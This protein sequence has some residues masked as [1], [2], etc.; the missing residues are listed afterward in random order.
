MAILLQVKVVSDDSQH[1]LEVLVDV[2]LRLLVLRLAGETEEV[3]DDTLGIES[4]FLDRVEQV[5][6]LGIGFG[7]LQ[8][9]VRKA[10]DDGEGIVDLVGDTRC[11]GADGGQLAPC[12][13]SAP[14][15]SS[16]S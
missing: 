9:H 7:L 2:D 1:R 11:Q 10:E 5:I 14:R 4:L 8:Q 3:F 16:V 6:D 15:A 13:S 12:E